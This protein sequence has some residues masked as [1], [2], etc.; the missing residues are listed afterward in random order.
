[1]YSAITRRRFLLGGKEVVYVY[2]N[3]EMP[4]Y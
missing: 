2:S 3:I 4:W 1:L